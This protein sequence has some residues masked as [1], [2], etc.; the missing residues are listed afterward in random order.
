MN[1][2]K[3]EKQTF[4]HE[5]QKAGKASGKIKLEDFQQALDG[6]T[7]ILVTEAA[8]AYRNMEEADY[9]KAVIHLY[10][11]D[12]RELVSGAQGKTQKGKTR[13]VCGACK[14]K[15]VSRGK[16]EALKKFYHISISH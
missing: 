10:C 12:C 2:T 1:N 6:V 3:D 14:S 13:L 15:K 4:L 16:E 5:A 8:E 9:P 11:H 7:N